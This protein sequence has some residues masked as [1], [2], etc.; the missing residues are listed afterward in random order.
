[1]VESIAVIKALVVFTAIKAVI[2][3][4]LVIHKLDTAPVSVIVKVNPKIA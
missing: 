4:G 1:M 2:I 3:K